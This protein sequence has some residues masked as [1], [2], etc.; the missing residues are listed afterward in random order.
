MFS[1]IAPQTTS[2][3]RYKVA[4]GLGAAAQGQSIVP[5]EKAASG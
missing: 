3:S 2:T 1:L 4:L 5:K